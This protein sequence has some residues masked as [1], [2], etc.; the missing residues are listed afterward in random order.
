MTPLVLSEV[1]FLRDPEHRELFRSG[2]R[3]AAA[4]AQLSR[5]RKAK[6]LLQRDVLGPRPSPVLRNG[7]HRGE[8]ALQGFGQKR[9]SRYRQSRSRLCAALTRCLRSREASTVSVPRSA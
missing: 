3:L 7:R 1:D 2:L 6:W 5:R 8:R 9:K 4:D